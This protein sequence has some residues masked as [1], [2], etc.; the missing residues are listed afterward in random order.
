MVKTESTMLPLGST[1]PPF[2]LTNVDGQVVTIE[3]FSDS[4]ALLVMFICNHCPYVIHVAEQL[5]VLGNEYMQKGVGVVAISANDV[6]T[7][8]ADSPEQM[9]REA[10]DRGY[11]FPYL[12]DE[13]QSVAKAYRAA[14]TPDFF[15]F[16]QNKQLTYRGQLDDSRPES[17]IPVTGTDLRAALDATLAEEPVPDPQKPSL[18]CN[19]KWIEGHEPEYFPPQG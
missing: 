4:R 10:E 5:A 2:S 19:I 18:G 8:P 14:C 9:V 11:P 6:S 12:Y 1:A 3:D 7:H 13:D 17:G 15:V 16:D